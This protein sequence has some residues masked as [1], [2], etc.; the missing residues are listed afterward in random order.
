MGDQKPKKEKRRR[1]SRSTISSFR[2][3]NEIFL[4]NVIFFARQPNVCANERIAHR[5]SIL[6]R[7]G[8]LFVMLMLYFIMFSFRISHNKIT[9]SIYH[10]I[11]FIYAINSK[12]HTLLC[13]HTHCPYALVLYHFPYSILHIAPLFTVH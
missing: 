5:F 3:P 8:V 6:I 13:T 7:I 11:F 1:K 10:R 12:F 4:Q 9:I 2:L